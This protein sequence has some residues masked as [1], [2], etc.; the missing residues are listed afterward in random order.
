MTKEKQQ[1]IETLLK[2]VLDHFEAEDQSVR[3]R[4]ILTWK[5]L[6]Y[7]W[8][9]FSRIWWSETAHDWR[10][11]DQESGDND[12]SYYDKPI[13]VFR[14]Y[15][16]SIIAALS[17]TIP[18]VRCY[19]DDADEPLDT[20]TAN[21]GDQ[22]AELIA[23]HN[24][25]TM[26]WLHALFIYCTE[27]MVA[28]HNYTKEDYDYG[29]YSTPKEE[30]TEENVDT[31]VCPTCGEEMPMEMMNQVKDQFDPDDSDVPLEDLLQD[32]TFCPKCQTSVE[33]LLQQKKMMVTRIVGTTTK[34]KSRQI[35]ECYG[36]L[37]VKVAN[38]AQKQTDTPYLIWSYETHFSN[39]LDR[40]PDLKDAYNQKVKITSGSG[41]DGNG[42]FGRWG[43]TSTQYFGEEPINNVTIRNAWL[44]PSSFNVLPNQED[45]DYLKKE[46]PSG[47]RC[48]FVDDQYAESENCSLDDEWTLTYNPLSDYVH[49]DPLGMLLTSV[50]EITND[51]TSLI[52]QTIE[53][54]IPQ[55]FVSPS[56]VNLDA[57]RQ[58]EIAPGSLVPTLPTGGKA[59]GD[60][61]FTVKTAM[62]S[63]EILPFSQQ[64]QEAGQ[65]VSGALPSLF[66]GQQTGAG[67]TAAEYSMSRAQAQQRLGTT[68]KM[69]NVWWKEIFGKVIPAYIKECKSDERIV[70]KTA[71]NTFINNFIHVAELQGKI[72]SVELE[73]SLELP[74][75]WAQKKDVIMQLL[76]GNNPEVM[77]AIASPENIPLLRQA[78]GLDDFVIP[79][80]DDRDKQYEEIKLLLESEPIPGGV[81]P[82]GQPSELPSIEI[83]PDVDNNAIEADICRRWAVS[84]IGRQAKID[85]PNGYKNVLLHMKQ[86]L[87]AD[88]AKQAMMQAPPDSGN[89]P[90]AAKLPQGQSNGPQ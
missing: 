76:Q 63:G 7:F 49:F 9:G 57:Y 32:N 55:T 47:A 2:T 43:R 28:A 11:F 74:A 68:W 41:G 67:K 85:N 89:K 62:L 50:Q 90:L 10:V 42:Y 24:N 16:E 70:S 77:A 30:T 18:T 14:A 26:L 44:R 56:T 69:F 64:I 8:A 4:Q 65:L 88:K 19:P 37:F 72:G 36:G 73:S 21:A 66:G 46:F 71:N 34:P 17:I 51:L 33:P 78:I 87:D 48:V 60:G 80:E 13:N 12:G 40:F 22:I 3:E 83:D 27:G 53:H 79:G 31:N 23:K 20:A 59:I 52:L 82:D 6:K 29:E 5:R 58:M 1:K 86:H 54:G 45:V 84:S 39:A 75:T 61:F 35:I 25:V 38:Y 15:L 81:G